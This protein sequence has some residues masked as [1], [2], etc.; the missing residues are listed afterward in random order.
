MKGKKTVQIVGEESGDSPMQVQ[1]YLKIT[2]LIPELLQYLDDQKLS[3]NPAFE[4]AFLK[5]EEQRMVFSA[6]EYTQSMP[7]L[8][9]AQRIKKLSH[10]KSLNEEKIKDILSE[11]KKSEI[12]R[13]TFKNEQLHIFFPKTDNAETMKR[14]IIEILKLWYKDRV[15]DV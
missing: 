12:N 5:E 6:M 13:V 14:K 15:D 1:R 10:E 7:S 9:Q 11:V 3:F 4:L 2:E 8:S